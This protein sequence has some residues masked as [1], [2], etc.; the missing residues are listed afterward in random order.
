MSED[1]MRTWRT[2]YLAKVGVP[3]VWPE[4][5]DFVAAVTACKFTLREEAICER[6]IQQVAGT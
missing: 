4:S 6:V 5:W 3:M 2:E 1:A